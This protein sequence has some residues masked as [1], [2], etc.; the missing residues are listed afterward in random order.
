MLDLG[1]Y[2]KL[3]SIKCTLLINFY[4]TKNHYRG[5]TH[6]STL[7]SLDSTL[8][9]Y[10]LLTWMDPETL[11]RNDYPVDN[12]TTPGI[13]RH[14]IQTQLVCV[15]LRLLQNSTTLCQTLVTTLPILRHVSLAV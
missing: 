2:E 10:L 11:I 14:L 4:R 3:G 1:Y 7:K 13:C 6:L 8:N 9:S 12:L 15:F 5:I